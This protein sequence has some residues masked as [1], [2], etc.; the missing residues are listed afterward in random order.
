MQKLIYMD[1]AATTRLC[2]EAV[3]AMM[4]FMNKYYANVGGAYSFA[5]Q[6]E[7]LLEQAREKIAYTINAKPSE[8]YF[9]SGGTEGDNQAMCIIGKNNKR[10]LVSEIEHH[11]VIKSCEREI[12]KGAK[13]KWIPVDSNCFVDL[14]YIKKNAG[15]CDLISVMLANNE[16]GVIQPISEIGKIKQNCILHTDAVQAYGHIPIDV[17]KLNVDILNVSAHKFCGPKGIGFI[18][19]K[20][21][22]PINPFMLG[23]GQERGVRSGTQNTIAI[24]GMCQAAIEAYKNMN[25]R[26]QY[27]TKLRNIMINRLLK[28]NKGAVINGSMDNRL[29]GNINIS[30]E[31][32]S[33]KALIVYLDDHNICVSRASACSNLTYELSHVLKAMKIDEDLIRGT[34]RITLNHE[35]TVKEIMHVCDVIK[36]GVSILRNMS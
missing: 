17:S 24:A 10:M 8:I 33:S 21:G 11:A 34:I 4:P 32:I 15:N 5:N 19:I 7:N 14:N 26:I 29:P 25:Y 16:T 6:C 22:T 23:G 12:A 30:F 2:D 35:N 20:E 36:E 3:S 9:N 13:V 31:G 27:E 28:E 18:Y 1:N